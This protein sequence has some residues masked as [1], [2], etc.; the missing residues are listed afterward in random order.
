MAQSTI[1]NVPTTDTATKGTLYGEFDFLVQAPGPDVSRTYIYNPRLVIG[2]PGD[3]EFGVNLPVYSTGLPG[4]SPSNVYIQPNAKWKLYTNRHHGLAAAVGGLVNMPLNNRDSQ[5]SW[6]LLYGVLSKKVATGD[7]WPRL[8]AGPY[9][10][11]SANQ[12]PADG[13]VSFVGPRG[14]VI[15]GYEQPVHKGISIVADWYSGT[16]GLGYLTTGISIVLP[17]SGLLNA[18]YSIGSDSWK[19]DNATRNRYSFVYY[20]VVF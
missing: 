9:G 11:V 14:G 6:G 4:D 1:F 3:L 10:I 13:P 18:G 7:Y 17:R 5:D 16:N 8:H 19:D 15:L 20:G 12:D 2:G